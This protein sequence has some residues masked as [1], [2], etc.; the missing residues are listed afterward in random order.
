MGDISYRDSVK[1]LLKACVELAEG[2]LQ[3]PSARELEGI[4]ASN[5]KRCTVVNNFL[6]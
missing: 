1:V 2:N 3:L 4:I 5:M 6:S